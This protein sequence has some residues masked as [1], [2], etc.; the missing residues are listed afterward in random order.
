MG[1]TVAARQ[2]FRWT[3]RA[4]SSSSS[5]LLSPPLTWRCLLQ[6]RHAGCG[7]FC[8]SSSRSPLQS[9]HHNHPVSPVSETPVTELSPQSLADMG[10]T[11]TQAEQ[12]LE[13][14]SKARGGRA[15]GHALSALTA[16][17]A[18][19]LNPSS[20]LKL[21]HKCPEVCSVK[22]SQLQQRVGNLRKLGLVE[23]SLQRVVAHYPQILTVP[24]KTVK[25]VVVLLREKCLFTAPQVT[26]ILRESPAIVLEDLAQVEFLFQYVYFR[27][28]VKQVEIIKSRLFRYSLDEVRCRH[29]FLERRGLYQTPDKKGQTIIINPKLDSILNVDQNAFLTAVAKASVEEYDVFQRLVAKEWLEEEKEKGSINADGPDSEE[30]EEDEDE[31]EETGGRSGYIKT[32]KR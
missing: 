31:E 9:S 3:V 13:T 15:A 26:D 17:L 22:E 2:V 4:A 23:G 29:C 21:L 10:F 28:G 30:E 20:V 18:L 6:P 12:M 14:A 16:L 19:G 32:R 11:E 1:T 24:V 5:S 7:L 27:M 25:H 8:S